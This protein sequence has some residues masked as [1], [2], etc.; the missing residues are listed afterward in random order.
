MPTLL[1]GVRW[2]ECGEGEGW[3]RAV[4]VEFLNTDKP[5]LHALLGYSGVKRYGDEKVEPEAE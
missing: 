2:G 1:V 4:K 5:D 3:Q